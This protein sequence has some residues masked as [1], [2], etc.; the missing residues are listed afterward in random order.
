ME[1]AE[2]IF[3][4]AIKHFGPTITSVLAIGYIIF[5]KILKSFLKNKEL[6]EE[7]ELAH[8]KKEKEL[9]LQKA[10]RYDDLSL[11]ILNN[12]LEEM[13]KVSKILDGVLDKLTDLDNSVTQNTGNIKT[14]FAG[15]QTL[16]QVIEGTNSNLDLILQKIYGMDEKAEASRTKA[17]KAYEDVIIK[18]DEMPEKLKLEFKNGKVISN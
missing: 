9:E 2:N 6:R 7:N 15:N 14:L 5:E 11:K 3:L 4:S 1:S 16:I 10:S 18:L 12:L 8:G 17:R 13:P